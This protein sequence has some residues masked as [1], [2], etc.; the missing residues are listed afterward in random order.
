MLVALPLAIASGCAATGPL[1]QAPPPTKA[2]G[3]MNN[4]PGKDG[5]APKEEPAWFVR[6]AGSIGRANEPIVAPKAYPEVLY[7][8][9]LVIV[10]GKRARAVDEST[11]AGCIL[12]YTCGMDGSPLV[13]DA[14]GERDPARSLAGKSADGI[15]PIGPVMVRELR[16][17]GHSISLRVNGEEVERA[18]TKMMVWSPARIVS[19]ISQR[20]TL[21]PGDVIFAGARQAVP[22]MKPGDLVVVEIDG[23]GLLRC[24]VVSP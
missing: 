22:S 18:H 16:S 24:P 2:F 14:K 11:A 4:M 10:I 9:E 13:K 17:E 21:E 19:E 7:E 12:G 8:G 23:I 6:A 1:P 3:M 20:T 5:S 15:A